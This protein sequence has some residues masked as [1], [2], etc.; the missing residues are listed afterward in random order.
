MT[1]TDIFFHEQIAPNSYQIHEMYG[2]NLPINEYV[3]IG[4]NQVAV[5]DTGMAGTGGLR[6]YIE[7]YITNK[8]PMIAY[9]T[10]GHMDHFGAACLFDDM[11]LNEAE[12]ESIPHNLRLDR[13]FNDIWQIGAPQPL[14]D[15]C[16][17][18]YLD[19]KDMTSF[20]NISDGDVIDLGGIRLKAMKMT[21]HASGA[22]VYYNI[23][24]NYIIASDTIQASGGVG[25][26]DVANALESI[27]CL[28]KIIEAT[29]EDV[30]VYNGHELRSYSKQLVYDERQSL[31]DIASG[32]I[33]GDKPWYPLFTFPPRPPMDVRARRV[34]CSM[35]TYNN[36]IIREDLK[37]RG[38]PVTV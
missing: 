26:R 14:M 19:N 10:H 34:G 12:W 17:A 4:E 18:N 20:K 11:Y 28:D 13:R 36:D 7:K 8:T 30:R 5:I 2:P 27:A 1:D 9:M 35:V 3:I 37:N 24:E 32:H 31:L 16:K 15:F 22:L 29:P 21:T 23:E 33:E 25:A 6:K 38:I